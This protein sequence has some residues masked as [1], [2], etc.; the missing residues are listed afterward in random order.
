MSIERGVLIA[1]GVRKIMART[2]I[3]NIKSGEML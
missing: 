3:A 1:I 2:K